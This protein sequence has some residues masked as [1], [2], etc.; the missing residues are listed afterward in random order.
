MQL[1]T[2]KIKPRDYQWDAFEA[3]ANHIRT[4]R[5]PAFIEASVGAGKTVMIGMVA[6]RCQDAGMSAWVLARQG[7]LVEQAYN[8]LWDMDVKCSVFSA[9]IGS[10]NTR[11]PIICGTEGTVCRALNNELED[12]RP[13]VLLIDESHMVDWEDVISAEPSTQYGQII[14]ELRRRNPKLRILGYTGSPFRGVVPIMGPFWQTKLIDVGT[15]YLVGRGYLTP[16]EFGFGHDDVQYD[17]SE[18]KSSGDNGAKD[19]TSKE[20]QAMQRKILKEG[21]TTQKIMLEIM[22][23]QRDRGGVALITCAGKK[24]CEEAAK[25]LEPETYGIVTDT[26]STKERKRILDAARAE[27][28]QFV[29]QIGCLTTGVDVPA[30]SIIAILRNIGSLTLLVQLI[31]RGLRPYIDDP[32]LAAEFFGSEPHEDERRKEIISASRKPSALVLDY[33]ATM[34]E[35]G[36][37]YHNPILEAAELERAKKRMEIIPCPVCATDNSMF[38]RRC[39]GVDHSTRDGRCEHF[40]QSRKCEQCGT[41]NDIA[42][43]FCRGCEAQLIDPNVKLTGKHYTDADYI[44]VERMNIGM[45]SNAA[46]ILVTYDL[47]NGERATE[48]FWPFSE[49]RV[50]RSIWINKFVAKHI[51]CDRFRGLILACKTPEQIMKHRAVFDVPAEITHRVNEKGKSIVHRKKFLSG[52]EVDGAN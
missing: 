10:K 49:K 18:F 13:D 40:W 3:T 51:N 17:L 2:G 21:T 35:L 14:H 31:G 16:T 1:E 28:L 29:F 50:A 22:A 20:L 6:K 45:T 42:A 44:A 19:F 27:N 8:T 26:T 43:R 25:Y 38:A 12:Q 41:E 33:S 4:S 47:T 39:I 34:H 48:V 52:R 7:E 24:H 37:L 5:N 11:Y 9:S 32:E 36:E 46:G 30:F 23:A 15:E